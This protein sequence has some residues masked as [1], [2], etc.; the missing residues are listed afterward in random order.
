MVFPRMD[1]LTANLEQLQP[2][3][4]SVSEGVYALLV[5]LSLQKIVNDVSAF[6]NTPVEELPE[7]LDSAMLMKVS[8]WFTD[9]GVLMTSQE[10]HES[11]VSSLTEGD[12]TVSFGSPQ[13]AVSALNGV[14]FVDDEF[15][16]QLMRHRKLR[17]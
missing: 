5:S 17:W 15:K 1:S 6:T 2:R 7:S 3:P 8:T 12:T 10:R 14:S 16:V 9:A 13:T 4:E 11:A